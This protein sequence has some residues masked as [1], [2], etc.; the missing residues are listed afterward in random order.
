MADTPNYNLPYPDDYTQLAD[1]PAAVKA[2]AEATDTALEGKADTSDI[3]D[4]THYVEDTDYANGTT[5]GVFKTSSGYGTEVSGTGFLR[6]VSKDY[7]TY[8][9]ADVA[10]LISKGTL[11]NVLAAVV[12]DINSM[13]DEINGEII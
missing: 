13:L 7:A 10:T 1:V 12:G 11:E 9:N 8:E 6:G 5:G 4:L 2:L 3:P